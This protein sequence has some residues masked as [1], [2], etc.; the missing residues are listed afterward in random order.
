MKRVGLK[1]I[2]RERSHPSGNQQANIQLS[3]KLIKSSIFSMKNYIHTFFFAASIFLSGSSFAQINPQF[4]QF[5]QNYML[6]NPAATG[7]EDYWD[8]KTSYRSQWTGFDGAPN[9]GFMSVS[10]TLNSDAWLGTQGVKTALDGESPKRSFRPGTTIKHGLGAYV[11]IDRF[12]P[13]AQNYGGINYAAHYRLTPDIKFSLGT[14]V[15]L[16]NTALNP[17]LLTS[18]EAEIDQTYQSYMNSI[19]STT[20]FNWNMGAWVYSYNFFIGYST[21]HITGNR[22]FFGD[23][24]LDADVNLHHFITAGYRV[25]LSDDVD[26]IP[27]FLA[28]YMAP[29]PLSFD[30]ACKIRYQNKIWFA[31]TYRRDDAVAIGVG[32]VLN[33]MLNISYS[34]DYQVSRLRNYSLG[35][36]EVMLGLNLGTLGREINRF[37]W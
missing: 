28:K 4:S 10:G 17:S 23:Q 36:H 19:S 20:Y 5:F 22:I 7:V 31:A 8:L 33:R 11:M 13:V 16:N 30:L 26:L 21:Q 12:G 6:I 34:Y 37:L 35:G 1:N 9:T 24:F 15:G 2:F 25:P 3:N 18:K 14:S 29:G 27:S 32:M